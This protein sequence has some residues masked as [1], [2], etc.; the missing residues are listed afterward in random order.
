M[1]WG[2]WEDRTGMTAHLTDTDVAALAAIGIAPM[3]TDSALRLLDEAMASPRP[4]VTAFSPVPERIRPGTRAAALFRGLGD[5][6]RPGPAATVTVDSAPRTAGPAGPVTDNLVGM[7]CAQAAEVLGYTEAV[8]VAPTDSF[9]ELG[10]DSLLSVDL[11]NR[12]NA[13][14]GLRMPAE[15]VLDN[16]TPEALA[17]YMRAARTGERPGAAPETAA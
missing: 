5:V 9:K 7:V 2:L 3:T 15:A 14:T 8:T 17:V 6:P 4:A 11:R 12:L 1:A 16:P 10:F 13:A